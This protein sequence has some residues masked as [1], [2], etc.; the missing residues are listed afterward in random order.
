[1]VRPSKRLTKLTILGLALAFVAIQFVPVQRTTGLG[2]GD[3]VASREV[4]WILRRACY[5][6]HSTETRWPIWAYVAPVSWRVVAD[7]NRAR[8]ALNFSDWAAYGDDRR[9]ALRAT[10]GAVTAS[11]RMPLWYY[12]T[13]HPDA[14][15]SPGE[16]ALL[17][18]WARQ[19]PAERKP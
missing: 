9:V 16:L 6:C 14:R 18:D 11:H 8:A 2:A 7:V 19:A 13:L 1:M 10:V 17:K 4:G 3:P 5:D 12:V 15:L